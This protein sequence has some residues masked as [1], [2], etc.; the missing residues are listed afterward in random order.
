[1]RV[2]VRAV[3]RARAAYLQ[4]NVQRTRRAQLLVLVQQRIRI[5]ARTECGAPRLEARGARSVGPSGRPGTGPA[6]ERHLAEQAASETILRGHA[7][8]VARG[9]P[10]FGHAAAH[11]LVAA[12]RA[13]RR[14]AGGGRRV[15][16]EQR[17]AGRR[18]SRVAVA[19]RLRRGRSAT[20]L[21]R[22]ATAV[23]VERHR[24]RRIVRQR[25][26]S[27]RQLVSRQR[28]LQLTPEQ[29][30]RG[31]NSCR[32]RGCAT[33]SSG[34]GGGGGGGG[35]DYGGVGQCR[36]LPLPLALLFALS[37]PVRLPPALLR[38]L[39]DCGLCI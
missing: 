32:S 36:P 35:R 24:E 12:R 33:A 2:R 37:L 17:R 38:A 27:R 31:G 34:G 25:L 21:V 19:V 6:L 13:A 18:R 1:M 5:C 14:A 30:L 28:D 29:L 4:Y 20:G 8:Q 22:S 23:G 11:R 16:D 26:G 9:R 10:Q 7:E 15:V 39:R 3:S